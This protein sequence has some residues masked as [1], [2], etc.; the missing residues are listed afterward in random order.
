MKQNKIKNEEVNVGII[1]EEN[2]PITNQE[3]GENKASFNALEQ[4]LPTEKLE[5]PEANL[6][7]GVSEEKE[8]VIKVEPENEVRVVDNTTISSEPQF[9]NVKVKLSKNHKC[10][11][12]GVWYNFEKG[13]VYPVPEYVK[14]I[15]SR[16]GLLLPL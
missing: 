9:R 15:L 8:E 6:E 12:G 11:I 10:S 2:Q 3:L 14:D 5:N 16:A 7:P 4:E 1:N 13:K